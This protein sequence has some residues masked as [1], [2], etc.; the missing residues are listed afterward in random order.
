MRRTIA[1]IIAG[2][3]GW[4]VIV[5][6]LNWGLRLWLPGY[7]QAEPTLVFTLGMKI[8]RLA[9]AAATS[10][11]AGALVRM[12]APSRLA[13]WIV[14][15]V[16]VALFAAGAHSFVAQISHLVPLDLPG[17]A[18]TSGG[19]GRVARPWDQLPVASRPSAAIGC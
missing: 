3:V 10:I 12:I 6:V 15:L 7:H 14:G 9:I 4:V 18:R 8:A 11:A 17:H 2:L 19:A 5:T 13:P 16:M 1:G